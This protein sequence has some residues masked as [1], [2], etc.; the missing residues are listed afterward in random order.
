MDLNDYLIPQAGKDWKVLLSGWFELLPRSF[1]LWMVNRFGDLFVVLDDDAVHML[2]VGIGTFKRLANNR[3]HFAA[4]MDVGDNANNWLMIPLVNACVASGMT[5]GPNQCYGY[6][7]PPVL[8]GQYE[9]GNVY[10]ADL[11]VH[12]AFLADIYRQTRNLPE[13][14]PVTGVV[15]DRAKPGR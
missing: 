7:I 9:V 4:L 11:A 13:G 2:D 5:L 1:T 10:P 15:F 8:S 3:N 6:K 12:Y 14:T